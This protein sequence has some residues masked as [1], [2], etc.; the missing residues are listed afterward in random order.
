MASDLKFNTPEERTQRLIGRYLKALEI[1][2][3]ST[4]ANG[5]HMD[6]DTLSAFVE[7]SLSERETAPVIRHLVDCSFC[8]HVST[9]LIRLD[10]ALV[11]KPYEQITATESSPTR[12]SDVLSRLF[13]KI[14]GQNEGAVFAHNDEQE[15]DKPAKE[16]REKK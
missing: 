8:R 9:E 3:R 12:I 2:S 6:E 13:S 14:L 16:D 1:R 7:G 5:P 10:A 11:D 15:Q 4:A